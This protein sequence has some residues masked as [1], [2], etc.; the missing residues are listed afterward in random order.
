M[1]S[2]SETKKISGKHG[3]GD[4]F[5]EDIILWLS[6]QTALEV[7]RESQLTIRE[8]LLNVLN[9]VGSIHAY[10]LRLSQ[11]VVKRQA[12]DNFF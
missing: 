7:S 3:T 1:S 5:F 8:K 9:E 4:F 12:V 6:R 2:D 11:T 10:F